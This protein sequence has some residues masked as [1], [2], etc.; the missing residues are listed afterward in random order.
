MLISDQYQSMVL[1]LEGEKESFF[2][3]F[4]G[5]NAPLNFLSTEHNID[6]D[7]PESLYGYQVVHKLL[8]G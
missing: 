7:N 4:T 1:F 2:H 5:N 8:I 6:A 3:Q